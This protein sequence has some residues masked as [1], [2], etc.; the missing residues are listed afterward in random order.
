MSSSEKREGETL[1]GLQQF[2]GL[3]LGRWTEFYQ[4]DTI[5]ARVYQER[6]ATAVQY[7]ESLKLRAGSFVLDA[8]C[9]PGFTS[10]ALAQACC[11]V[12]PVDFL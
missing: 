6:Q 12:H 9:G 5:Y 7:A 3:N 10:I 4:K 11:V 2:F 1:L 8:G